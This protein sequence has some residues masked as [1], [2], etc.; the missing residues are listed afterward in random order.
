MKYG[1]Q[2][3]SIIAYL[4]SDSPLTSRSRF[5]GLD[6]LDSFLRGTYLAG[7]LPFTPSELLPR[8]R[9]NGLHVEG[10]LEAGLQ[11]IDA[12]VLDHQLFLS[13]RLLAYDALLAHA[14]AKSIEAAEITIDVIRQATDEGIVGRLLRSG[15]LDVL[16]IMNCLLW[17]PG[18]IKIQQQGD[19]KILRV[20]TPP[21]YKREP[22]VE[23][24][25]ISE[26]SQ[27]ATD[28]LREIEDLKGFFYISLAD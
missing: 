9:C 18:S 24:R 11:I 7:I 14:V 4:R 21:I 1:I 19:G 15:N 16:L 17:K 13:S 6:H 25:P 27:K 5:L 26:V 20:E 28:R 12:V 3:Q 2:P 23:W 22:L 8:L 10:D